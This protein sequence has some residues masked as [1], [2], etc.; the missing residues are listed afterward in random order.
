[1]RRDI[2]ILI[3]CCVP[4]FIYYNHSESV[5]LVTITY[6]LLSDIVMILLLILPEA[7]KPESKLAAWLTKK[8]F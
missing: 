6:W 2:I 5:T 1:M 7:I 4:I 3:W 8:V